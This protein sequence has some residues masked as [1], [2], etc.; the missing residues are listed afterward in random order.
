MTRKSDKQE[1]IELAEDM[2]QRGVNVARAGRA[3]GNLQME[4]DGREMIDWALEH[5]RIWQSR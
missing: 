5:R 3:Q 1:N 4:E 2:A